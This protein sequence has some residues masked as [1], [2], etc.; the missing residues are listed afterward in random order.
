MQIMTTTRI[1]QTQSRQHAVEIVYTMF[2]LHGAHMSTVSFLRGL[3]YFF[4]YT[5]YSFF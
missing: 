5:N 2:Y 4:L 3:Q 1:K